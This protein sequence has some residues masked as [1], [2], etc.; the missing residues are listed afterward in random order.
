[1]LDQSIW[2]VHLSEEKLQ[3]NTRLL[4]S[5]A[6]ESATEDLDL[7]LTGEPRAIAEEQTVHT[8]AGGAELPHSRG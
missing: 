3:S 6:T 4:I 8:T 2:W 1:M 5:S 7:L